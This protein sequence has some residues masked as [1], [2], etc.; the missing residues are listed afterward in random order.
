MIEKR[1]FNLLIII[2]FLGLSLPLIGSDKEEKAAIQAIKT[3]DLEAL[4]TYL[5][6]HPGKNCEFSDGK[7][8]L[9][10]AI[11]YDRFEIACYL[12]G[13]GA[14]P[15]FTV[16]GI[17]MLRWA[18]KSDRE[19]IVRLLIEYGADVNLPDDKQN[20]P[21]FYAAGLNNFNLCKLLID[22][23]ADPSHTNLK[24]KRASSIAYNYPDS[25]TYK[26][27]L[28]MEEQHLA[29]DTVPSMT[30]GPYITWEAD[31]QVVMTYFERNREKNLTR[32]IEKTVITRAEDTLIKG[33]GWDTNSYA[34]RRN[35]APDPDSVVTPGKIFVVGDIHGK[36]NALISLLKNNKIIG[37]DLAWNFGNG[38][39]V[40]LGDV[41][42]RGAYVTEVL[43]F[44]YDLQVQ[45]LKSGGDVHLLL[46]NHEIMALERD[47]RYLNAK[48][49]YFSEYTQVYYSQL[50]ENNSVL[51]KWLRSRNLILQ[52]NGYLFL[53]AGISPEFADF[54]FTFSDV[55]TLVQQ[56]LQSDYGT[57]QNAVVKVILGS[58]GPLWYRGYFNTNTNMEY[59][60]EDFDKIPVVAQKFVDDYLNSR[61]LKRMVIGHNEQIS[62]GTSY[63]GRI[64]SA[65][66]AID[67][68]GQT[69]QGLLIT[70]DKLFRCYFDG[71][72]E[73]F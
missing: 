72:K 57:E 50:F 14:D 48:Y 18:I 58:V 42:D 27:L 1:G 6:I 41:F 60:N 21:L 36:Y 61:G 54:G 65:D 68:S 53:H 69:S 49:D 26:Y 5:E 30:D 16:S 32:I 29:K 70:G 28:F 55:N 12:L 46:G 64:I 25:P 52:I 4:K 19:R 71:R 43:W 9:Y 23:G 44:L 15:D 3:G 11:E 62:I 40:F 20:A 39:L 31:D 59:D 34:I 35:F 13:S 37:T 45:A 8:G 10:Y 24:G 56:Y 47:H 2:V 38:Q 66:V 7:T 67:E 51:G 33:F 22:R 73:E 17:S 63:N